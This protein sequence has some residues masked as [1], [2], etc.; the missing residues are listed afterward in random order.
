MAAATGCQDDQCRQGGLE[1][2]ARFHDFLSD[3]VDT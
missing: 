1:K 2:Q 3:S